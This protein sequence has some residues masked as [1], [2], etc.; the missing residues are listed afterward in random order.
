VVEIQVRTDSRMELVDV[1]PRIQRALSEIGLVDGAALCH[2][3]HT[4]AGLTIN[5]G[6]DPDVQ[7]D[8]LR[9]LE[10]LAPY[11]LDTAGVRDDH[12]EGNSDAHLKSVLV[13]TSVL[14]PV[15]GGQIQLGRWQRVFFCEFDGPRTRTIW[16]SRV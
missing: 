2:A 11:L 15:S 16:V 3:P 10:A 9:R 5:E 1:T 13:G 12:Q 8:L 7:V 6:S 4:T 14:V